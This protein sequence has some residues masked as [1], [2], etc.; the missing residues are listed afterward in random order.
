MNCIFCKI[1]KGEIPKEFAYTD[2]DIVAFSDIR[3][4]KP[5]HLLVMPKVH[6]TDFMALENDHILAKIRQVIQQL[7]KT[8][9][10]EG[11]GFRLIVNGAGAQAIDH[12]HFHLMGPMGKAADL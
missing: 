9:H 12:L 5:V 6:I 8:Q 7:V 4:L 1:I 2:S 10:L 11:K 3:P